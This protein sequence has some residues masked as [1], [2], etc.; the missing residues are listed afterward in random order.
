MLNK[1]FI[2]TLLLTAISCGLGL[3]VGIIF[4]ILGIK[5]GSGM[6]AYL[7]IIAAL[8]VGQI[9]TNKYKIELP[10][11]HK[12]KISLYYFAIQ[13]LIVFALFALLRGVI[14]GLIINIGLIV[15]AIISFALY[16]SLG[17]GCKMALKKL[18]KSDSPP[19]SQI[20]AN[21]VYEPSFIVESFVPEGTE[22]PNVRYCQYCGAEFPGD[23]NICPVCEK[24]ND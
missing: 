15:G 16:F 2:L 19:E 24:H 23:E 1:P 21:Q 17:S 6:S 8:Y 5:S 9:Y 20:M 12:V 11:A 7:V 18:N 10:K 3:L 4:A 13:M 14:G 22:I